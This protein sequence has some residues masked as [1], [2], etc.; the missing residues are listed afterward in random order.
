MLNVMAPTKYP[1]VD[2]P[3]PLD[4]IGVGNISAAQMNWVVSM[5]PQKTIKYRKSTA[6]HAPSP[7][8]F[9]VP[10]YF[11]CSIASTS[12]MAARQ[13]KPITMVLLVSMSRSYIVSNEDGL[14]EECPAANSIDQK[15]G[16]C[17]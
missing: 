11:D 8:W 14:T 4:R 17:Y 9:S 5:H 15:N 2:I 3:T 6:T 10:T 7:K 12:R 16:Y 1:N 13:G